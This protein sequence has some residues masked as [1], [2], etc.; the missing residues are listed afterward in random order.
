LSTTDLWDGI[1]QNIQI[2]D[3]KPNCIEIR[4]MVSAKDAGTLWELRVYVREKLITF[5]QENY[6]ES[7]VHH[8]LLIKDDYKK[9]N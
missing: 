6:P 8:R 9:D 3:S 5:L 1:A 7:I 4:A 2:T